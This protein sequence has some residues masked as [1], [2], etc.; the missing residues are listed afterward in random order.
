MM[1]YLLFG[2]HVHVHVHVQ[3]LRVQRLRVQ[4][5]VRVDYEGTTTR[6]VQ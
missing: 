4:R 6:T 2:L 3:R 1:E 5:T